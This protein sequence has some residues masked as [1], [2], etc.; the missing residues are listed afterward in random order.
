MTNY[1]RII[2]K[3]LLT[4]LN[5]IS[6][7]QIYVFNKLWWRF[8]IHDLTEKWVDLNSYNYFKICSKMMSTPSLCKRWALIIS[9]LKTWH[10]LQVSK[11]DIQ[12]EQNCQI[13]SKNQNQVLSNKQFNSRVDRKFNVSVFNITAGTNSLTGMHNNY[14]FVIH[15][16]CVL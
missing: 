6:I 14:C 3:L 5:K 2:E 9:T 11:D 7:A 4:T 13:S 16:K 10:K 1:V 12:S 15:W 8:S